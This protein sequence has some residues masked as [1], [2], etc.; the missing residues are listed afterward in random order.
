VSLLVQTVVEDVLALVGIAEDGGGGPP[1]EWQARTVR[2]LNQLLG[3]WTL[4]FGINPKQTTIAVTPSEPDRIIV[5]SNLLSSPAPDI[6]IELADIASLTIE[7]G[8]VVYQTSRISLAEYEALSIKTVTSI[9][10][11]WAWDYQSPNSNIWLYPRPFASLVVRVTGTQKISAASSQNTID[12]PDEYYKA[13][14]YNAAAML[15]P[16]FPRDAGID[17]EIIYQ[18]RASLEG[19]RARNR[20]MRMGRAQSAYTT[21][22]PAQSIWL[23]PLAPPLGGP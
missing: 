9:P 16:Y 10:R 15:Y 12:L 3:E 18:A 22:S 7:N 13:L 1:P 5:G 14:V 17:Q 21:T 23:S 8:P 4:K 11:V 6:G 20:R 19:I 2:I